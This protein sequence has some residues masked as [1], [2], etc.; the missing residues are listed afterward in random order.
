MA[1]ASAM[2]KLAGPAGWTGQ[3]LAATERWQRP[4]DAA[5]LAEIDAAIAAT[6]GQPWERMTRAAFPLPT[7]SR[8]LR[9]AADELENGLGLVRIQGLPVARYERE[10]LKRLL[11]GI[12][13]HLGTPVYQ[14]ARGELMGEITDEGPDVGA[15]RGQ[16]Q[17]AD[18]GVF[19]SSRSRAQSTA[20]LRW[21]TDRCD[22]VGL[23]CVNQAK[24]GGESKIASAVAVHNVMVERRPD[25]ARLLYGDIYRSRLGE[26]VGGERCFYPLPVFAQRDGRFSTHYSRTFVEA[27]QK[28]PAVPK[29]TDAQWEA[30]D[31]L[32]EVAQEVSYAMTLSPGDIQLLNNH[33]VYHARDAFEDHE[34]PARK[35]LLYRI[36]LSMPNSRPLPDGFEILWGRNEGGALRGGMAQTPF[37]ADGEVWT[38]PDP[39]EHAPAWLIDAAS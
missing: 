8:F 20:P 12:G 6:R 26:E 17:D 2:A 37:A 29:M 34:D 27:A 39:A 3:D 35:R 10:D 22:V 18:G 15:K 36:W 23:L 1:Q 5:Q 19:L 38:P 31:M 28:N 13:A 7:V 32:A 25:L 33:V 9:D 21:H 24:R 4:L 16:L 30:L 14:N 11:F